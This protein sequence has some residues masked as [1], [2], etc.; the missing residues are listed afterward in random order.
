MDRAKVV[1]AAVGI[2]GAL[3]LGLLTFCAIRICSLESRLTHLGDAGEA[4]IGEVTKDLKDLRGQVQVIVS[5]LRSENDGLIDEAVPDE[6]VRFATVADAEA[7]ISK[8]GD[9]PSAER[10]AGV[11]M[12]IDEWLIRPGEEEQFKKFR[13]G[14]LDR[15]RKL[16]KDEVEEH[17]EAALKAAT[18][19]QGA[20][21]HAEAG[22]LLVLYPMSDEPNVVEEAKSLAGRQSELVG[23]LEAIRRQR[24][25]RWA[26][27]QVETTLD[28]FNAN[29]S[30]YNPF[31]DNAVLIDSLVK[32]LGQVDP[33]V[34]EP[35]VL[36]LY[37]YVIER[38]K[39][40][41]SEKNKVELAKRL[42]DPAVRRKA[43]GDF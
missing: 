34:L 13:L 17:Q 1:Y 7:E 8:L 18:G 28:Y 41:I 12:A 37:N 20:K 35:S 43:L 40:S 16:V 32:S 6:N 26:A 33:V 21:E 5:K 23:R 4:R 29:V 39:G 27:G 15:L 25:N 14:H 2:T 30:H 31:N 36:E 19:A 10:L 9:R 24:Y 22:R 42:T 3:G 11:L 38:T